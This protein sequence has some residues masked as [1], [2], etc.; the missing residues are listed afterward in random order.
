MVSF[1]LKK[2]LIFIIFFH[3]EYF[4]SQLFDLYTVRRNETHL[5]HQQQRLLLLLNNS[6]VELKT[7]SQ[8]M[9]WLLDLQ[10][11]N[12]FGVNLFET[13]TECKWNFFIHLALMQWYQGQD[14]YLFVLINTSEWEKLVL[15]CRPRAFYILPTRHRQWPSLTH[16]FLLVMCRS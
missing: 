10:P 15:T 9:R 4:L 2:S 3:W 12:S 6:W 11:Y 5:H 16:F 1:E 7:N 8:L 14:F 13:Q